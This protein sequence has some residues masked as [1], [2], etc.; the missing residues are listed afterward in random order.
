[1]YHGPVDLEGTLAALMLTVNASDVPTDADSLPTYSIYETDF[2]SAL[3]TGTVTTLS[4]VTGAYYISQV[5]QAAS[6]FA[7]GKTYTILFSWAIS[8]ANRQQK[9]TFLV[10]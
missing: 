9:M 8:A 5:I 6:S 3:V 1:M 7:A 10:T 4:A 2:G